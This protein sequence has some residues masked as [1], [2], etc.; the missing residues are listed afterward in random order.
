MVSKEQIRLFFQSHAKWTFLVATLTLP[1]I[2][3]K[4]FDAFTFV[5]IWI[6]TFIFNVWYERRDDE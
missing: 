4:Y 2:L 3:P 1:Q 5:S 6:C